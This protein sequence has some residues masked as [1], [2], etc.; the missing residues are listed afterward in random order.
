MKDLYGLGEHHLHFYYYVS[1]YLFKL[2]DLLSCH[3][4]LVS[5]L[6]VSQEE[7]DKYETQ[8]S[9]LEEKLD[10][11]TTA[12][13]RLQRVAMEVCIRRHSSSSRLCII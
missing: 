13:I 9:L 12:M 6:P 7:L 11:R 2:L 8:Y 1:D 3:L 10:N 5:T 4:C